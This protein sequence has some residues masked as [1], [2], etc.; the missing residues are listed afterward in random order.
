MPGMALALLIVG[1]AFAAFCV[2]LTVRIIDRRE[3]WAKWTLAGAIGL[4]ALWPHCRCELV[5]QRAQAEL[6]SLAIED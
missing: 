1:I 3:R 6:Q 5:F 2:W 4:P